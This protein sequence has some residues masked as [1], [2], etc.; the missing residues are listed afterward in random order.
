MADDAD[1]AGER[2]ERIERFDRD[3]LAAQ[4][5]RGRRRFTP[6]MLDG[7]PHCPDCLEPLPQHRQEAGICVPCLELRERRG[8]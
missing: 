7:E 4:L 1:R 3:A 2:I 5:E 8:G 6:H